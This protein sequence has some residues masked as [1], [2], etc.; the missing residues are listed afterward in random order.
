MSDRS[1]V[2]EHS[3]LDRHPNESVYDYE[4]RLVRHFKGD[5]ACLKRTC[6]GAPWAMPCTKIRGHVGEC[7]FCCSEMA[8]EVTRVG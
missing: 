6:N 1:D 2:A 7:E 4:D 3:A 8:F 5:D